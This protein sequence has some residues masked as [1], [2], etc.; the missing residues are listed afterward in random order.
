V[1]RY[2]L[3]HYKLDHSAEHP[4][5]IDGPV[6]ARFAPREHLA[7]L[8][9]LTREPDGRYAPASGRVDPGD[10]SLIK[11]GTLTE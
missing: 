11:L 2:V 5:I 6:F 8:L 9:F 3:H 4:P 1:K 10:F 7:Y